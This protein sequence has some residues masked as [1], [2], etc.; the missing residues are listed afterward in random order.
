[1]PSTNKSK[2]KGTRAEAAACIYKITNNITKNCYIG[3]TTNFERRMREHTYKTNKLLSEDID[4]YTW[5]KFSKEILIYGNES[6][7]YSLEDTFIKQY[8]AKYNIAR[9]G[10]HSGAQIGEEHPFAIFSEEDIYN[11]RYKYNQGGITQE[12]LAKHYNTTN[13]YI[14][15]IIRGKRWKHIHTELI[16]LENNTNKKA[17]RS[18]LSEKDVIDIRTEYSLGG[19]TIAEISEIYNVARQNISKIL[20]GDSWNQYPGPIRGVDYPA[21]RNSGGR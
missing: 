21:R 17:N 12:Q 18:K 11:I 16:S 4:K 10:W 6:Y 19:I 15:S 13:K 20:D 14:S 9:G 7:C 1:M 5:D 8:N 2:A 3:V